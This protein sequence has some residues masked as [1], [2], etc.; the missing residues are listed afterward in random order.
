MKDNFQI[1]IESFH[2]TDKG[3]LNNVIL[4]FVL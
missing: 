2:S 4:K 1:K 3:E